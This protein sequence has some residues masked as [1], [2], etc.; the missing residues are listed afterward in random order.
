[1]RRAPSHGPAVCA[2]PEMFPAGLLEQARHAG[3]PERGGLWEAG[4]AI[5]EALFGNA[6]EAATR[7]AAALDLSTGREVEFAAAFALATA[8][9]SARSEALA[10][11]HGTAIPERYRRALSLPAGGSRTSWP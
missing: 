8:G 2:N 3:Q 6:R 4:A 10:G 7:A 9:D 11:E 5:R 1:M